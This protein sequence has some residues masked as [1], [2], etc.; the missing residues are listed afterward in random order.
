MG[1]NFIWKYD[2]IRTMIEKIKCTMCEYYLGKFQCKAFP[3]KIPEKVASGK[4]E[5]NEVI[6][7]QKGDYVFR[8]KKK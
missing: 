1:F 7:G 5:H 2:I 4:R 3:N 8:A 6:K